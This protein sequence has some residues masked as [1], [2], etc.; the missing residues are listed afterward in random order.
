MVF[1]NAVVNQGNGV[2]TINVRVGVL[3]P[4]GTV[5]GPASVAYARRDATRGRRTGFDESRDGFSARRPTGSP[6]ATR[7]IEGYAS[8]VVA[9]VF[10]T[11]KALR[12]IGSASDEPTT[13]M[14]P[15]IAPVYRS[16]F[17]LN[18]ANNYANASRMACTKSSLT[19]STIT[20]N[21]GSVPEGR[22]TIRTSEPCREYSLFKR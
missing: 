2:R 19:D 4:W 18:G 7:N 8:G 11:L 10:Q 3:F 6:G 17:S 1:N 22:E 16:L 12:R 20:R 5:R 15:H 21:T 13:P 14:M 9:A